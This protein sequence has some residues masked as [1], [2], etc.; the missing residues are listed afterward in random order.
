MVDD[1]SGQG[2]KADTA[3]ADLL[4]AILMT[5]K[6]IP[7]VVQA[8]GPQAVQAHGPLKG[9]QHAGQIIYQILP[10]VVYVAGMQT[11]AQQLRVF[12][13]VDHGPKFFEGAAHPAAH[14]T[15]NS[16]NIFSTIFFSSFYCTFSIFM[17]LFG[18]RK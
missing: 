1:D 8:D 5:G 7:A 9:V 4:V 10:A 13:M 15:E 6:E 3:F 16:G 12:H 18:N 2:R 14:S 11:H 17:V